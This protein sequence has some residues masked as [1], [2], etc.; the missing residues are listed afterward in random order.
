LVMPLNST[1]AV[2]ICVCSDGEVRGVG[3]FD[4]LFRGLRALA[5]GGGDGEV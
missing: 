2:L 4:R 5:S 1:I 3:R